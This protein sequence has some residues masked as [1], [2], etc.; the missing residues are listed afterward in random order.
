MIQVC[1]EAAEGQVCSPANFNSPTQTV[2]AGNAPAVVR[3]VAGAKARGAR[4]TVM[5]NVSAPFHCAL[6]QKA[7][8]GLE[9][10]LLEQAFKD[11]EKPLVNNVD[12]TL[13][14]TGEAARDGLVR[15]VTAPVRWTE[16]VGKLIKEGVS[17]FVEVGPKKVLSALIKSINREVNLMHVE[18]E[19]SLNST[20]ESL[21]RKAGEGTT[22]HVQS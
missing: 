12:A 14:T 21:K 8:D 20:I 4:H 13:V 3:A 5:L 22:G 9:G 17:T 15:Q 1:E 19:A 11:L 16:S 18:D 10:P 6:M 7:K 2:I